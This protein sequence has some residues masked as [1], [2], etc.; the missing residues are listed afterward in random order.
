MNVQI[1]DTNETRKILTVTLDKGEVDAEYQTLVGEF[2]EVRDPI[3]ET[4]GRVFV[5]GELWNAISEA[6]EAIP[7]GALVVVREVRNMLLVVKQG[8]D[9]A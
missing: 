7:T 1:T 5:R 4:P 6:G 3:S 2:G 9:R 8:K